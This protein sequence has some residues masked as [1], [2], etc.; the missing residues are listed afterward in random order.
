[1]GSTTTFNMKDNILE[2]KDNKG[3]K[4]VYQL[5]DDQPFVNKQGFSPSEYGDFFINCATKAKISIGDVKIIK[6]MYKDTVQIINKNISYIYS[7][8]ATPNFKQ[9]LKKQIKQITG[10]EDDIIDIFIRNAITMRDDI[11]RSNIQ[12]DHTK[13][14]QASD[15][16]KDW[17]YLETTLVGDLYKLLI[18][19]EW[20]GLIVDKDYAWSSYLQGLNY[21]AAGLLKLCETIEEAFVLL[22]WFRYKDTDSIYKNIFSAIA[23]P[24]ESGKSPESWPAWTVVQM[25]I[26]KHP[27]LFQEYRTLEDDDIK[28]FNYLLWC[29]PVIRS[30]FSIS[31]GKLGSSVYFNDELTRRYFIT[32]FTHGSS[33]VLIFAYALYHKAFKSDPRKFDFKD[34]RGRFKLSNDYKF[35]NYLTDDTLQTITLDEIEIYEAKK[36]FD[37]NKKSIGKD[38]IKKLKALGTKKQEWMYSPPFQVPKVRA[39][40]GGKFKG[41]KKKR[42]KF[43]KKEWVKIKKK[44]TLKKY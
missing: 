29:L 32:I 1:M 11:T 13:V 34:E 16:T 15:W 10:I 12:F 24:R 2:S 19:S 43:T 39:F 9:K 28:N 37:K 3:L 23:P 5:A 26:N 8:V 20:I 35:S 27:G 30:I 6:Q 14:G 33:G 4:K 41:G 25:I 7:E 18:T 31:N 36:Y 21:Q 22:F 42:R 44:H 17:E 38:Y 40:L